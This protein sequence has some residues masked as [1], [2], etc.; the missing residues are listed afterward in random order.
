MI[1]LIA[2]KKYVVHT[3]RISYQDGDD[4]LDLAGQNLKETCHYNIPL[5][6]S[7]YVAPVNDSLLLTI[8]FPINSQRL[9]D[10]DRAAIQS[11]VAPWLSASGSV[12]FINGYTDN[13]GTPMIN[14][15]LSYLRAQ[16]VSQELQAMGI[17]EMN[18]RVKGWGEA[19]P[20]GDNATDEG[21]DR[22]RRVEVIVR[23]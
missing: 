21:K 5:L 7:D 4:T 6:P 19:D 9:T 12:F 14:E 13:T 20:V 15:Q 10:S 23:R 16:I 17:D 3:D 2:G 8:Q 18:M 22:N 1:T 11:V